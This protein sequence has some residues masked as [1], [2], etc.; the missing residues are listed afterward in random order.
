MTENP[1]IKSNGD[2]SSSHY[3]TPT[4][5]S[6]LILGMDTVARRL[7]VR[8]LA[9]SWQALRT[10]FATLPPDCQKDCRDDFD[11]AEKTVSG[12]GNIEGYTVAETIAVRARIM[13]GCLDRIDLQ[14]FDK[15]KNS[16]FARGY[17]ENAPTKPRNPQPTMLGE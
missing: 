13:T 1:R 9:G 7:A 4:Y 5:Q 3:L 17:L 12:A 8:D 16:L 15:I 2:V 14:L 10:L 6:L 11:A